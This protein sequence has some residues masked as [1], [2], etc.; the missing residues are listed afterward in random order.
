MFNIKTLARKNPITSIAILCLTLLLIFLVNPKI[1]PVFDNT[2]E[3][4]E[5]TNVLN[6]INNARSKLF[7]AGDLREL[8]NYYDTTQNNGKWSM[9]HEIRRIKY[10][11]DWAKNRG[12][13]FIDITS[14]VKIKKIT[15]KDEKIRLFFD[16]VYQFKYTYT[17]HSNEIVNLFG[18]KLTHTSEIIKRDGQWL[19]SKD[20]YLDCFEDGMGAY[21]GQFAD[22]TIAKESKK[23]DT[24][25]V[26]LYKTSLKRDMA[27]EYANKYCGVD[28]ASGSTGSYNKKYRNYNGIGGDCTNYISQCLGDEEGGSLNQDGTWFCHYSKFGGSNGSSAWVNAANFKNYLIYSGKGRLIAK[29]TFKQLTDQNSDGSNAVSRLQVGDIISYEKKGKID[30]NAIVTGFDSQGYPL[31]NTHTIDRYQVPWD[32]GWGNKEIKFFL[33]H[34]Q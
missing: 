13:E 27:V 18:V 19:V 30:H 11:R 28:W 31:V 15:H 2:L 22:N 23:T 6:S 12:I 10:L 7:M 9:E 4:E 1:T 21:S 20:W 24:Q 5:L 8:E 25:S 3:K 14:N 29:G 17:S 16:E 33:I 34:I 26:N 32:L